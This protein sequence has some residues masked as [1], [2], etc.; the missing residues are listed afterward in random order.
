MALEKSVTAKVRPLST[1]TLIRF[2]EKGNQRILG[3]MTL[4]KPIQI[5]RETYQDILKNFGNRQITKYS[6]YA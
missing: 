5:L 3:T 6:N 2:F 1:I 4:S